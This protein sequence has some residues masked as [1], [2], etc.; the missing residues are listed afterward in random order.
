VTCSA[1]GHGT[2]TYPNGDYYTGEWRDGCKHGKG[3]F[4]YMDGSSYVGDWVDDQVRQPSRRYLPLVHPEQPSGWGKLVWRN[5]VVYEGSWL[6]GKVPLPA[7]SHLL[8]L[9]LFRSLCVLHFTLAQFHGHGTLTNSRGEMYRGEFVAGKREGKGVFSS[10]TMCYDG[11]WK[12]DKVRC[13]T[14]HIH[15]LFLSLSL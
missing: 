13:R 4:H 14:P 10:P 6:E 1:D 2:L 12:E 7:Y 11:M 9:F 8:L 15:A 5:G 3:E